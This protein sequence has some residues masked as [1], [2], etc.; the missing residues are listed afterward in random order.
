M[1]K[2]FEPWRL[3]SQSFECWIVWKE[4]PQTV[5]AS[6]MSSCIIDSNI[7][8]E[9]TLYDTCHGQICVMNVIGE[10]SSNGIRCRS[11]PSMVEIRRLTI[12]VTMTYVGYGRV[13]LGLM[14]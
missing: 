8:P 11:Q 1:G 3:R 9:Q 4:D 14:E 2:W 13:G 7:E 5:T 10:N 12:V 6:I